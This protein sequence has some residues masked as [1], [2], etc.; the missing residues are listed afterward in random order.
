MTLSERLNAA[1]NE[2]LQRALLHSVAMAAEATAPI[3]QRDQTA[4]V[5]LGVALDAGSRDW[6]E[7]FAIDAAKGSESSVCSI[8]SPTHPKVCT[9]PGT[10][11]G[12]PRRAA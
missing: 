4:R 2:T 9:D 6:C 12:R 10:C 1:D 3:G 11:L 7:P 8:S 5:L